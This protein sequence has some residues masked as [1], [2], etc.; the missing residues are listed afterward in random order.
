MERLVYDIDT[1]EVDNGDVV[2]CVIGKSL[3]EISI[4]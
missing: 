3:V 1:G 4:S 2:N